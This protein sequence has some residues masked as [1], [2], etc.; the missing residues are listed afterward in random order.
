MTDLEIIEFTLEYVAEKHGDPTNSVY[1][2]LFQRHDD[3]EKFFVLDDN[4]HARGNMLTQVF[5][6]LLDMAGPK[7]YGIG[8]ISAEQ[9]NHFS[10][11]GVER[12]TFMEFFYIVSE[13]CRDM[14][15]EKWTDEIDDAWKR[16]LCN[17][18]RTV[19]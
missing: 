5:E 9:S 19:A 12:Q 3:L 11:Y 15:G 16:V 6:I 18:E 17:I 4:N 1:E 10:S 8:A 13:T 2:R 7:R 14:L